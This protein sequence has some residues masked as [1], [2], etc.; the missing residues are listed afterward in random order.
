MLMRKMIERH[1]LPIEFVLDRIDE[2][3]LFLWQVRIELDCWRIQRKASRES[4]R[5]NAIDTE[6]QP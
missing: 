6:D 5:R 1:W 3:R 4:E 2:I